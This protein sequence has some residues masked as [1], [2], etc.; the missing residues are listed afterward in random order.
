MTFDLDGPLEPTAA[1]VADQQLRDLSRA[2]SCSPVLHR[3]VARLRVHAAAHRDP[4]GCEACYA[5]A[6]YRDGLRTLTKVSRE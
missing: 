5:W 6:E 2:L 1:S 4:G 3:L